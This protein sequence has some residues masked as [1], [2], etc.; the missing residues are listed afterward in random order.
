MSKVEEELAALKGFLSGEHHATASHCS[1]A[2]RRGALVD[3]SGGDS[4]PG[5]DATKWCVGITID[6][7]A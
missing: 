4:R 2:D 5:K 7:S 1:A 6:P 3:P